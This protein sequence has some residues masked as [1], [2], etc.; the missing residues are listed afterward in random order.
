LVRKKQYTDA[1]VRERYP[2]THATAVSNTSVIETGFLTSVI[3]TGFL[4]SIIRA[5]TVVDTRAL[6]RARRYQGAIGPF[7]RDTT[8]CLPP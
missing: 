8:A 7:S 4:T 2:R 6:G 1:A 5:L 3:E